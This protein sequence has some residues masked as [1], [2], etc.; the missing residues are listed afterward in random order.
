MAI[1]SQKSIV[2]LILNQVNNWIVDNFTV[3]KRVDSF[4]SLLI[5]TIVMQLLNVGFA[6]LLI[7]MVICILPGVLGIVMIATSE[8]KRRELRN[9]FCSKVF[10]VTNAIP[11]PKF[12]RFMVVMGL[13]LI[14][15]SLASSWFLLLRGLF[16]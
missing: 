12:S 6:I 4:N 16:S 13:L 15:F 14:L 2:R 7:K 3:G 9:V 10:G 1:D 11:Y 5:Y 8:E